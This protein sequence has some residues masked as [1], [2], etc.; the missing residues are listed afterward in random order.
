LRLRRMDGVAH[1]DKRLSAVFESVKGV[2]WRVPV[3]G[4]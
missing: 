3:S 4:Q 1:K 2:T